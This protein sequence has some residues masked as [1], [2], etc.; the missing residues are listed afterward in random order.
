MTS[1]GPS[2]LVCGGFSTVI[3]FTVEIEI[4]CVGGNEKVCMEVR[5]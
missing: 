4:K 1:I 2:A 3:P 5:I